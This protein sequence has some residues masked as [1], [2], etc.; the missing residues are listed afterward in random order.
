[1]QALQQAEAM[2]ERI[3][4]EDRTLSRGFRHAGSI[5]HSSFVLRHCHDGTL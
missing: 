1:M 4:D 3:N 2:D 5:R